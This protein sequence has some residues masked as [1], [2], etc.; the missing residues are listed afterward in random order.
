MCIRDRGNAGNEFSGTIKFRP[1]FKYNGVNV[2]TPTD[3]LLWQSPSYDGGN[4][5]DIL[6]TGVA[7]TVPAQGAWT[8]DVSSSLSLIHIFT[9]TRKFGS[10]LYDIWSN[11]GG[12]R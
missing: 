4:T 1:L 10:Y 12:C 2:S 5:Y 11:N 3:Y 8:G 9:I 6:G 7:I